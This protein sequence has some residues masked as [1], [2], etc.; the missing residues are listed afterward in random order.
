MSDGE[1][2]RAHIQDI[3]LDYALTHLTT[4]YVEYTEEIVSK[5]AGLR[6]YLFVVY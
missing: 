3:L 1:T 5:V 4:N 2:L 6:R